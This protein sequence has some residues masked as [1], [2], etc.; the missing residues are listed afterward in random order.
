M[1]P[2]ELR[3]RGDP[4]WVDVRTAGDFLGLAE[5]MVLHAGPPIEFGRM[6]PLHRRGMVNACLLEKWAKTEDEAVRLLE[7][8]EVRC[9]AACD[10]ATNGSG[11]GIVTPSIPLLIVE[12]RESGGVAGVFPSEGRFGGGFCGGGVYTPEIAANLAWM[13]DALFP[14]LASVLRDEGGF[15][16]KELFAEAIRMGD[17]LHSSQKAI[18]ALFTRA[19]IPLELKCPNAADL[20]TYF[21]TADRFTHNFGQVASRALLL[22]LERRGERGLMSAAGGNGVD[23]GVKIDGTWHTAPSPMIEGPY[24]VPGARREN[25]LPWIGDSSIV[26]CRGWGGSIRPINPAAAVSGSGPVINGGMIDV[27]GGWMGAGSTRM[28]EACFGQAGRDGAAC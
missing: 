21:A 13:R 2:E 28:P 16:M 15:S 17:E 12:D 10:Y 1:K 11:T 8:G 20:L 19:V 23:Y 6:C 14:P 27:N 3:F 25:Q 24:L 22:G 4:W 5:R 9:E 7:A 18:D 26:E